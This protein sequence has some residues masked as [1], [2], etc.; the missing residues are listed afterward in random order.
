MNEQVRDIL[1]ESQGKLA[2]FFQAS[3]KRNSHHSS[4]KWFRYGVTC[5]K[6]IFDFH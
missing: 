4:A 5:S 2:E 1:S 3:V 6:I